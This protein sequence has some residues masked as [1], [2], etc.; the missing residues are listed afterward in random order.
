MPHKP[1]DLELP[2]RRGSAVEGIVEMEGKRVEVQSNAGKILN[3][4][5]LQIVASAKRDDCDVFF[6][7]VVAACKEVAPGPNVFKTVRIPRSNEDRI[8]A[9]SCGVGL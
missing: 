5:V 6:L 9:P 8:S 7:P 2:G 3:R 4:P 1:H